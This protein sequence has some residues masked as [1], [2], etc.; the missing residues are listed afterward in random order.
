M[1]T[2]V[3]DRGWWGVLAWTIGLAA[4]TVSL[5]VAMSLGPSDVTPWEVARVVWA[6]LTGG[7]SGLRP[8]REAIIWDGRVPRALLAAFVGAGLAICGAV[9]Q[10]LLRNPLADPYMLGISSGAGLGAVC[11]L[12]L[13]LG[14]GSF[15]V[16][17]AAFVGGV[18]A[19]V[20]VMTVARFAGGA[21]TVVILTGVAVTQLAAA[22]TSFVIFAFANVHQTRGAMFWLMG[23]LA[24]SSWPDVMLAAATVI[25]GGLVCLALA[26]Y[27]DAFAFGE[28]AAASLGV[29][30]ARMRILLLGITA[31]ITA[32]L[33][34]SSGAIGFVGLTL[35]HAARALVGVKHLVLLP[36]SAM[37]GAI[38]LV[39]ADTASRT[40]FGKEELP[41]GVMTAMIG[42]PFFLVILLRR[43]RRHAEGAS[44]T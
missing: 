44:A 24:S 3:R 25:L 38:F 30:V 33:V 1:P 32:V 27:L 26:S 31:M 16:S 5:A 21:T 13:G 11:V 35:P 17:G 34:S 6:E 41:V 10:S 12:V 8:L 14:V 42:V 15:G 7:E 2:R 19:F 28:D 43:H 4:L 9:L 23:S 39:W 36:V 18:A 40:L 20:L 37:L 22:L 29:D